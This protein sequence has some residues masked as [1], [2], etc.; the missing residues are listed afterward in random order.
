[1]EQRF[2]EMFYKRKKLVLK[3]IWGNCIA[4]GVSFGLQESE[5]N[6]VN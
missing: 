3:Y 4:L 6:S 2:F 5:A 1:M